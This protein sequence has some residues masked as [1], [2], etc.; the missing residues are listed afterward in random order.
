[1]KNIIKVLII[2]AVGL[3]LGGCERPAPVIISPENTADVNRIMKLLKPYKSAVEIDL[4]WQ[5][6]KRK[7]DL[8]D[9]SELEK[10]LIR[11]T[12]INNNAEYYR[13]DLRRDG[14]YI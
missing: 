12:F 5:L 6:F 10:A 7:S 13:Y 1:M 11:V 3:V 4:K 14:I 8:T 9:K 2:S